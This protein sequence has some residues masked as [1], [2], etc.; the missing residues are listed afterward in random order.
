MHVPVN[1]AQSSHCTVS[2]LRRL[3][4]AES[5]LKHLSLLWETSLNETPFLPYWSNYFALKIEGQQTFCS[6]C[7]HTCLMLAISMFP[8]EQKL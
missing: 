4:T 6:W 7:F 2:F 8:G 3:E 1:L 5:C